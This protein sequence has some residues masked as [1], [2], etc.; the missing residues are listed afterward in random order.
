[1]SHAKSATL[2][3]SET[4]ALRISRRNST[5]VSAV[6]RG[7]QQRALLAGRRT[8]SPE[9][10]GRGVWERRIARKSQAKRPGPPRA[11]EFGAKKVEDV[12]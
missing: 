2:D 7:K 9:H 11:Q 6:V 4:R 3:N 10:L 1:M 8:G 12:F 5:P